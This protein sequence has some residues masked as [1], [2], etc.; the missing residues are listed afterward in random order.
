MSDI[1]LKIRHGSSTP[2]NTSLLENELGYDTN[3]KQ[4]FIG[5][6]GAAPYQLT[7][8]ILPIDKGGTGATT[9]EEACSNI[10]AVKKTG[11]IMSGN[12]SFKFPSVTDCAGQINLLQDS[13]LTENYLSLR[14]MSNDISTTTYS[15]L[16]LFKN[17]WSVTKPYIGQFSLLPA[18]GSEKN[19]SQIAFCNSRSQVGV[20]L[21][22]PEGTQT[23]QDICQF[24]IR[25]HSFD[26]E[27]FLSTYEQYYLPDSEKDLSSNKTYHILTTKNPVTVE[28]GGT[29]AATVEQAKINLGLEKVAYY[30]IIDTVTDP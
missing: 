7:F 3:T 2:T 20:M 5:T 11:D 1:R 18:S 22:G 10:G 21:W 25:M 26:G 17:Y 15:D 14:L 19:Y 16:K 23:T 24:A 9:A 13:T 6:N 4:L 12:L 30:T 8:N 28:Q 27:N 29:G